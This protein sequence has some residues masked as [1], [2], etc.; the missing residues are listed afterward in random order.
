M[1]RGGLACLCGLVWLA[2]G[3]C[4]PPDRYDVRIRYSITAFGSDHV[5]Q[6]YEMARFLVKQGFKRDPNELVQVDEPENPKYTMMRG[7]IPAATARTLVQQRHIQSILL[8]PH[9]KPLPDDK[10]ERVRVHL[11]LTDRLPAASRRALFE[12]TNLALLSA[13]FQQASAYDHRGYSRMVGTIPA[14]QVDNLVQD[15]RRLPGA[16][17]L[18]PSAVL[19]DLRKVPGGDGILASILS[20]W[21][22][23]PTGA[24]LIDTL[25]AQWTAFPAGREYFERL[26]ADIRLDKDRTVLNEFLLRH[27]AGHP[28]SAPLLTKLFENVLVHPDS[29]ELMDRFL[30]HI[31]IPRASLPLP[32]FFR[33]TPAVPI[34]EVYPPDVMPLPPTEAMLPAVPP[35]LAKITEDLRIVLGDET[36][37]K[38]PRRMEVVLKDAP[39]TEGE[40]WLKQF[41]VANVIVEGKL[42]SIVT[43]LAPAEQAK[44]LAAS[45]AV[46]AVR[47]A[48][49][50]L[51]LQ[52]PEGDEAL[53]RM[54]KLVRESSLAIVAEDFR[55]WEMH[56]GKGLP[57]NTVLI[58][59]TQENNPSLEPDSYPDEP[60]L[61]GAGT[62]CA[63]A[64]ARKAPGVALR[65]VRIDPNSPHQLLYLARFIDGVRARSLMFEQ[66]MHEVERD[67]FLLERKQAALLEQRRELFLNPELEGDVSRERDAY[68]AE[69]KKYDAEKD[70]YNARLRRFLEHNRDLQTLRG[71]KAVWCT[72]AWPIGHPLSQT[73]ELSRYLDDQPFRGWWFQSADRLPGQVWQELFRDADA[74]R[75]MEFAPAESPTP[76][77]SWTHE[78]SFLA[79]KPDEGN[80]TSMSLPEG[81]V[82]RIA[83]QWREVQNPHFARTGADPYVLPQDD[84]LIRVLRQIDPAGA[85]QPAD[86]ME[87][88]AVSSA[89]PQRIQRRTNQS[90]YEQSLLFRAPVSGRYAFQVIRRAPA[91]DSPTATLSEQPISEFRPLV[92]VQ[93][94]Q[95]QGRAMLRDYKTNPPPPAMPGDALKAQ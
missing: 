67:G 16:W 66:R 5:K 76:E 77:G 58:D 25:L 85:N 1:I 14:E 8:V 10:T 55:G 2:P 33:I 80:D 62:R 44:I 38:L 73:S 13:G 56:R 32:L 84:L 7:E 95:G 93:T 70:A 24:K 27:L 12:E 26:P 91:I 88:V 9:G 60:I 19:A 6:Y 3:Y 87:V 45:P 63:L 92:L 43:I 59:L 40:D 78:L 34:V 46:L 51:A 11:F 15:L 61:A 79:W 42:G 31:E 17:K 39:P 4:A 23:H 75:V 29:G 53:D 90:I 82:V 89:V 72:L 64:V 50:A 20:D 37:A 35:E 86:E 94:L 47:L 48:R 57:E 83:L 54:C 28:D 52:I 69:L 21:A 74:N 30:H 41:N 68:F 18:L 36:E 49:R 71:V 81:A 22:L 65:L